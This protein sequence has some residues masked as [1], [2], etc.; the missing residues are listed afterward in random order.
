LPPVKC[1]LIRFHKGISTK[2]FAQWNN[3][4]SGRKGYEFPH[5]AWAAW[6]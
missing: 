4:L 6:G 3:A 1:P 5:S 2:E